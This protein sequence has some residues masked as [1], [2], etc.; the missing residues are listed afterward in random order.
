MP[1]KAAKK[2]IGKTVFRTEIEHNV[3]HRNGGQPVQAIEIMHDTL[4]YLQTRPLIVKR[5]GSKMV[6][7]PGTP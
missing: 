7:H 5:P 6:N 3:V 2:M 4:Q 1:G